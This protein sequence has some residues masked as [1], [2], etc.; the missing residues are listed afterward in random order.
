MATPGT[1]V[2]VGGLDNRVT[3][4]DLEDEVR[5]GGG[6][7]GPAKKAAS[8]A[9]PP[10]CTGAR[11]PALPAAICARSR[12]TRTQ[13]CTQ[14]P[15]GGGTKKETDPRHPTTPSP[16]TQFGRHGR[17]RNVWV[18]R[19][20]PGFAFIEFDDPRDADDA[21]RRLDGAHGWRVE[22]S[23]TLGRRA[24]PGGPG[25]DRD[26]FGGGPP[27][28]GGGDRRCYECGEPG[29]LA[30]ECRARRGG[31]GGGD[32][33]EDR[34]GRSPPRRGR[35]YSRS[36]SR[37]RGRGSRSASRSPR[38]SPSYSRSPRRADSPP[39][40]ADSP[41]RRSRDSRSPRRA[42][43]VSPRRSRSRSGGSPP[44]SRS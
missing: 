13:P 26:R 19:K 5:E 37:S 41:P 33:Y 27:G 10:R 29:H 14:C 23:R 30:R 4:R 24:P 42:D 39:R 2:Y 44:R 25:G 32:R 21:V 7:G 36:R 38:R 35:S 3:E 18:A 17:L 34:R 31:G 8:N 15:V 9:A 12:R 11:M 43:P 28:G 40:R 1:R 20:P 6:G 16:P 22:V